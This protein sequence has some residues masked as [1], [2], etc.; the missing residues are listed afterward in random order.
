MLFK[1]SGADLKDFLDSKVEKYNRQTFIKDDPVSIPH[2]F[3]DRRDIEISGLWASILAWGLRSTIILSCNRLFAL[4][5][6]APYDFIVNHH[7]ND[8]K[9]FLNFK[10]RTFNPTDTLYFISFLREYY[11]HHESLE[12]GFATGMKPEDISV[13]AGLIHFHNLF[14]S[15]DHAPSRTMKHISTPTRKSACKRLNMFLRWMVRKDSSGVDFGLWMNIR[16]WQLVCP[17][18]VHVDRVARCLGLIERKSSDWKAALEL[19]HNLKLMDSK[20]PVKYDYALF[21][22]GVIEKYGL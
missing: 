22:L 11:E 17:L 15:L 20:D 10:H 2:Q 4:M 9:R 12:E 8:L 18:D 3:K 16:P 7:E 5:D 1:G 6:N 13:E 19:T 21:G 14:F